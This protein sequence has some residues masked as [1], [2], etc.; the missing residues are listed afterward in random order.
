VFVAVTIAAVVLVTHRWYTRHLSYLANRVDRLIDDE[1]FSEAEHVARRALQLY[2]DHELAKFAMVKARL[3]RRFLEPNVGR[4]LVTPTPESLATHEPEEL[5]SCVYDLHSYGARLAHQPEHKK[6]RLVDQITANIAPS[7]WLRAGGSGSIEFFEL[8]GCI[9]VWQT[10]DVQAQ[11]AEFLEEL[12]QPRTTSI[13]AET[14][15]E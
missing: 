1:R 13:G 5:C 14:R 9:V 15:D 12:D 7:T 3:S 11:V 8:N 2:P 4:V 6:K 10:E